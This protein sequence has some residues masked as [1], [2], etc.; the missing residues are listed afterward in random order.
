MG[1]YGKE[2]VRIENLGEY[3][4]RWNWE[5]FGSLRSWV[6]YGGNMEGEGKCGA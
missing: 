2:L 5:I 4:W 1:E 6:K 3:G